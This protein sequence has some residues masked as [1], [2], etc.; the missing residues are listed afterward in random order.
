MRPCVTRRVVQLSVAVFA[1]LMVGARMVCGVHWLSDIVGG[2]LLSAALV[3]A[4]RAAAFSRL[5]G[6]ELNE[7][8][9]RCG[10][11]DADNQVKDGQAVGNDDELDHCP[12]DKEYACRQAPL[13]P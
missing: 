6:A 10:L 9:R 11:E 13:R 8:D 4:Y 12:C 3:L 5:L 1:L 2:L 7:R